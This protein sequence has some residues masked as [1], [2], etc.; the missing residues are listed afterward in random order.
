VSVWFRAAVA[1]ACFEGIYYVTHQ[2]PLTDKEILKLAQKR[3]NAHINS[4]FKITHQKMSVNPKFRACFTNNGRWDTF[5]LPFD[6]IMPCITETFRYKRHEWSIYALA[7]EN[8]SKLLWANKGNDNSSTYYKGSIPLLITLARNT[9]CNTVI[10]MHNHPH[11]QG[12]YWNLLRPSDQDITSYNYYREIFNDN[13]LNYIVGVC[14]QGEFMIYGQMFS[15]AYMPISEIVKNISDEN[16]KGVKYSYK[17]H[18]ERRKP[19][20]NKIKPLQ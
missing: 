10:H 7:N 1:Y 16:K 6:E 5:V 20:N 4:H 8:G 17:L 3:R 14:T 15:D 12:R 19:G 9:G 2:R 18:L 11:T 13:G